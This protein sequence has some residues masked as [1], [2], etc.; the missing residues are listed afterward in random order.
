MTVVLYG[1]DSDSQ[2][3]QEN[4]VQRSD[5]IVLMSINPEEKNCNGKYTA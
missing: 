3:Q 1:I 5:S 2:R 4:S